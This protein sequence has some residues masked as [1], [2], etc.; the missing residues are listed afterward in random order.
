MVAD[1]WRE[2]YGEALAVLDEFKRTLAF[3]L[4]HYRAAVAR[5][6]I[7]DDRGERVEAGRHARDA[8]AAAEQTHSGFRHHATLGLVGEQPAAVETRLRRLAAAR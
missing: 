3:P 5:A 6:L 4:Q 7:A 8:L 2:L 1:R